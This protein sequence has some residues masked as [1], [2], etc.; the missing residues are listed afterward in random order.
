[1][2]S[3][4]AID[5]N[6]EVKKAVEELIFT[7]KAKCGNVKWVKPPN[8]HLTLK[9]L[10]EISEEQLPGIKLALQATAARHPVFHFQIQGSGTFPAGGR[11][12][13]LWVGIKAQPALTQVYHDLEEELSKLDFAREKRDFSPHLTI[14][15]VRSATGLKPVL[16]EFEH[17]KDSGFGGVRV[18]SLVLYKSTLTPTGA[19][20]SSMFKA[21]LS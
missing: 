18:D 1:M 4:I 17:W 13:I 6:D 10:G 7:L 15:R 16:S 21:G 14:G 8:L 12:R 5:L 9:F 3:F 2:R 20:Y 19:V 11:P